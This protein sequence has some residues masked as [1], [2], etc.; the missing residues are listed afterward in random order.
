M[1]AV[2][3]NLFGLSDEH[4]D[5]RTE[6]AVM[7][8]LLGGPPERVFS[9][10]QAPWAPPDV[11]MFQEVVDR[12]LAAHLLPHLRAAGYRVW[13]DSPHPTR[14]YYEVIATRDFTWH[15]WERR[16][17]DSEQGRELLLV[18]AERDGLSFRLATAHLESMKEGGRLRVAQVPVVLDA[19]GERGLFGGDTNLREHEVSGLPDAWEAC[20]SPASERITRPKRYAGTRYDRF[21]ARGLRVSD[22]RCLGRTPIAPGGPPP[23]DHLAISVQFRVQE[24]TR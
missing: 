4:L 10:A 24:P 21:W 9:G 20:G 16:P 5:E 14:E 6:A 15:A 2:S 12:T 13:P 17:L 1:R 23:S 7:E 8:V 19:L 11:L 18:E 22:F 3:Y